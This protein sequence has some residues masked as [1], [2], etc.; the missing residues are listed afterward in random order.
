MIFGDLLMTKTI[1]IL[2]DHCKKDITYRT[3]TVDYRLHLSCQ[4]KSTKPGN[5]FVTLMHID[6]PI[7]QE[8][9]FCGISCLKDLINERYKS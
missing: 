6:L 7:D 3:N 4:N 1:Q 8:M 9:H 5:N 2:C